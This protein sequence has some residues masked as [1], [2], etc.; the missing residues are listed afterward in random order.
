MYTISWLLFKEHR[1]ALAVHSQ[2][3]LPSFDT[4][5]SLCPVKDTWVQYRNPQYQMLF[6][7]Q[8]GITDGPRHW[9]RGPEEMALRMWIPQNLLPFFPLIFHRTQTLPQP[10]T[11]RGPSSHA[12]SAFP[13]MD[14]IF[15]NGVRKMIFFFCHDNIPTIRVG[16]G[17]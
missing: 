4:S 14:I 10:D 13:Q 16:G 5:F 3:G 15:Q 2:Q 8:M 6:Q 1:R 7:A 9:G 12:C 17:S 11:M